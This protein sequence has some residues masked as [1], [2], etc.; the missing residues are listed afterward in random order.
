[1]AIYYYYRIFAYRGG[2]YSGGTSFL[3]VLPSRT[4]R[5]VCSTM[6][7]AVVTQVTHKAFQKRNP[8]PFLLAGNS[9]WISTSFDLDLFFDLMDYHLNNADESP[10][11]TRLWSRLWGV[12]E[13]DEALE[14]IF[15][16]WQRQQK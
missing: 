1:M 13:Q 15:E 11:A 14:D 7:T 9:Q 16:W 10:A 3:V 5:L 8:V 2:V 6:K 4:R 12:C